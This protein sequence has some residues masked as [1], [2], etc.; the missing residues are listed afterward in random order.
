MR[1]SLFSGF[2]V[3]TNRVRKNA[4]KHKQGRN[5]MKRPGLIRD[6]LAIVL[7][8]ILC[9]VAFIIFLAI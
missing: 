8:C 3:T 9:Y 4:T 2:T 6:A 7:V 5:E 1:D